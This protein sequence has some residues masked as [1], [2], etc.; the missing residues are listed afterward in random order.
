M[1]Q[2]EM[3]ELIQ[4]HLHIDELFQFCFVF[5]SKVCPDSL[6]LTMCLDKK[7]NEIYI[8]RNLPYTFK[9]HLYK[10]LNEENK[11]IF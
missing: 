5:V 4:F 11:H 1:V 10:L 6:P 9:S 2:K 7:L 8:P 3:F